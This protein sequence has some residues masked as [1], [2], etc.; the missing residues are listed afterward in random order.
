MHSF[1]HS[2]EE[3]SALLGARIAYAK[4]KRLGL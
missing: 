3:L 4:K 2:T 1:I